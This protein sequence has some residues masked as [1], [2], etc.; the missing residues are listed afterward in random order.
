M[1]ALTAIGLCGC[2][3]AKTAAEVNSIFRCKFEGE[4]KQTELKGAMTSDEDA[5][6]FRFTSP[7]TLSGIEIESG[8]QSEQMRLRLGDM[9]IGFDES[10]Y[11]ES[12]FARLIA[13][14]I[15][16]VGGGDGASPESRS[17]EQ[18]RHLAGTVDGIAYTV[19]LDES[20]NPVEIVLPDYSLKL[21]LYDFE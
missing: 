3:D 8:L 1:I 2:K 14:I 9:E 21:V 10:K 19:T 12:A 16:R 5:V 18:G 7:E 13:K 15:A 4:Y 17:D 6:S 20:S 11:P